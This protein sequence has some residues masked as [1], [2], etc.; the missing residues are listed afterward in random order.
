MR[1]TRLQISVLVLLLWPAALIAQ[2]RYS[3]YLRGVDK[4]SAQIVSRAAIQTSFTNR[5]SCTDYINKLPSLLQSAGYVTASID[6]LRYDSTY[7]RVVLFLGQQYKW[8][9]LD[10]KHIETQI[11]DA[12]GWREKM[13]AGKPID[14]TQVKN[15]EDRILDHLENNGFPFAK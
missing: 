9:V 8:A 5:V 15:W 13:F 1:N 11:L 7:A 4:D 10:A 6:S 12:V 3:L 14:F 2:N